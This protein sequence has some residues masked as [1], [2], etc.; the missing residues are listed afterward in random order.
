MRKGLS[1]PRPSGLCKN[2]LSRRHVRPQWSPPLK[3]TSRLRIKAVLQRY[4]GIYYE[5]PVPIGYGEHDARLPWL[6]ARR[7]FAIETKAGSKKPTPKQEA[8]M[9]RMVAAGGMTFHINDDLMTIISLV[10]WLNGAGDDNP[11]IETE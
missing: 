3:A 6:L 2:V 4:Q 8:V 11:D 10:T 9:E 5:M 7:F 1:P